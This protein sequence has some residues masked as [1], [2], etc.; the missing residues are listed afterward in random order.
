M[1]Y[2]FYPRSPN[3][4]SMSKKILVVG[5]GLGGLAAA[6]RLARAGHGVEVW[7]KNAEPGGKLKELRVDNFRWGTGPSLLTMPYVLR[8]LFA[9]AGERMEDHLE[10]VRLEAACRYFWTDS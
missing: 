8:E 1:S 3:K 7:E 4:T 5:A 6:I 9:A 10:L 2:K